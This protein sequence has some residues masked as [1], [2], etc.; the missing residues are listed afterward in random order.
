MFFYFLD[1]LLQV[2]ELT[3]LVRTC[4]FK[5]KTNLWGNLHY[6]QLL[7]VTSPAGL[8]RDSF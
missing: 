2:D 5:I 3:F 7:S 8:R 4:D 6:S 1:F